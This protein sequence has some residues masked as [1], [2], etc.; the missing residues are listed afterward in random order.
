MRRTSSLIACFSGVA[1]AILAA[2]SSP[3]LGASTKPVEAKKNEKITI[4]HATGNG[5]YVSITISINGLNGHNGHDEDIIP[6]HGS[7]PGRNWD[8]E[9][10]ATWE[11]GCVPPPPPTPPKYPIGVF[12]STACGNDGTY[13]ATF[14]YTSENDVEVSI[15]IG[16][17]NL[18]APGR[19][20]QGQPTAFQPGTVASAF[21]VTRIPGAVTGS[22][23]VRYGGEARSVTVSRPTNCGEPPR[24]PAPVTVSVSCVDKGATTYTARFGYVNPGVA[25]VS[26]P[27]GPA[28]GF[29]PAPVNRGQ[30]IAFEP[31]ADPAAVE[32][33]GIS[34]GTTLAWTVKSGGETSRATA[35]DAFPT[36]C[37]EPL[38]P[39]PEPI[40]IFVTCVDAGPSTFTATF[41]YVNPNGASMT[42][43]VGADNRLSPAPEDRGQPTT[44]IPGRVD[45]AFTVS[46]V[47][48]GTNLVWTLN[49]R[50]ATA[51]SSF[52]T[53]CTEQP[54]TP[55]T[56]TDQPIGV[57]VDCVDPH[58]ATY[59]ATFGYQND[60]RSAVSIPVGSAN[61][62]APTPEGR[63]QVTQFQPGNVQAAFT[64]EGIPRATAL[65]WSVTHAGATRT[66]TASNTFEQRCAG[67]PVSPE[68]IGLYACVTPRGSGYD[69]TFG[70]VNENPVAVSIPVGLSNGVLPAP[71][72]RGQ[73]TLF[74]PGSVPNAFTV[75]GVPA[76]GRVV[77]RVAH[78][79]T[80]LLVVSASHP[81]RCGATPPTPPV[82]VFPLCALKQGSTYVAAFGY[83]N[84]GTAT[85]RVRRG[86]QNTVSPADARRRPARGVPPRPHG[87]CVRD[88]RRAPRSEGVLDS[89]DR[90]SDGHGYGVIGARRLPHD[91]RRQQRPLDLEDRH[92]PTGR[93]R[94]PGRIPD[95]RAQRGNEPCCK[96]DRRR[97]P[98]GRRRRGDVR[99]DLT[100]HVPDPAERS[101]RHTRRLPSR[102][103]GAERQR[104]D[105]RG[106]TGR[107]HRV[108]PRRRRRPRPR[109]AAATP[110]TTSHRP[111]SPS[112]PRTARHPPHRSRGEP[113][114]TLPSALP[115]RRTREGASPDRWPKK[116]L[117]QGN[118]GAGTRTQTA[119]R[120]P[121]FKS[122]AYDQFRHPGNK[123]ECK[124][125][126][127][128]GVKLSSESSTR[129]ARSWIGCHSGRLGSS[130]S[131]GICSLHD[132]QFVEMAVRVRTTWCVRVVLRPAGCVLCL[133]LLVAGCGNA[134][135][136]RLSENSPQHAY[137]AG[138]G[139]RRLSIATVPRR[140]HIAPVR[141]VA[142][143]A[144]VG[145]SSVA[146]AAY[147]T[148]E[149]VIREAPRDRSPV[150]GRLGRLN[151]HGFREVLAVI[152][153]H[154]GVR[155]TP[156]WYHVELSILP[157]GTTG[158]V[159]ASAV[160]TYRAR[161][162]IVIDVSQR[163]LRL[164]RSGK[165]A[166]ETPVA[167]GAAATPTPLGRYFVNE[168]YV[169]PDAGGP[170]GPDALGISAH[171]NALEHVWVEDGPIGIHGTNEPWSIGRAA[172]HGCIRVGNDVMRRLFPLAPAGT[173]VVIEN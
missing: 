165:L 116:R 101:H 113:D 161:S 146:Y 134:S 89:R 66:A 56:E 117:E 147:V 26:V 171:S 86:A 98:T 111:P 53:N 27:T 60:N 160:R 41:G 172:S 75:K 71:V 121:D 46:A 136:V 65:M 156:D 81:V 122:G 115:C 149:A 78:N 5:G 112:P 13:D 123:A 32:V 73:P 34:N 169:L 48:N 85:I 38:P 18:V 4:C 151:K 72:D 31:G 68:P 145:S 16:P 106:G 8:E 152:G 88:P 108:F 23:T 153:I 59:D 35:S 119:R 74:V 166:F 10:Q 22:W 102:H 132:L 141:C 164:F 129:R 131:P 137:P 54:P 167:V 82:Q 15:P 62:F 154:S 138:L 87:D 39:E 173:P 61:A 155:C 17:D 21:T 118:A 51:G 1:F 12:A 139:Q 44:F 162:R 170:F 50:T 157:N 36:R 55:P 84:S 30:P 91:R 110:P 2:G 90:G 58:G 49:G 120:P 57:F 64:V 19:Q 37:T 76:G 125:G 159:R 126:E 92:A 67:Q 124:R 42:V 168:R 70:Y 29:S 11:N 7:D 43:P 96:R 114:K 109:P 52:T 94:R 83:L 158:W 95:R 6:P 93:G 45:T 69:I 80:K 104:A 100:R 128:G 144:P 14:G 77:W 3:S 28:N 105:P 103:R 47:P 127:R 20:D 9:G 40:G 33:S 130:P 133:A 163:R 24:P 99:N 135:T 25:T 79:G 63:G 107:Q 142:A 148:K 97:P 143:V 140:L 150:V